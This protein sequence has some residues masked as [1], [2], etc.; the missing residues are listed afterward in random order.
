M[1]V[2]TRAFSEAGLARVFSSPRTTFEDAEI[3]VEIP[4]PFL[5]DLTPFELR[6]SSRRHRVYYRDNNIRVSV[7]PP[8]TE[9][10]DEAESLPV[11]TCLYLFFLFPELLSSERI[12]ISLFYRE[13]DFTK[14]HLLIWF[15]RCGTRVTRAS[16]IY[17]SSWI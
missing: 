11:L 2:L 6:S 10:I 17:L 8:P 5:P 4:S 1:K 12:G 14:N 9:T 16:R 7:D 15:K 3:T 13:L